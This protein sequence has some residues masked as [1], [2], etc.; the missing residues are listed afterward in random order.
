MTQV[1]S[2]QPQGSLEARGGMLRVWERCGVRA[3]AESLGVAVLL[4][5]K[6][7]ERPRARRAGTVGS[8]TAMGTG[9]LGSLQKVRGPADTLILAQQDH[10]RL[11]GP[12]TVTG[13]VCVVST[14]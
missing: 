8:G 7:E 11:V 10:V 1:G 3:V 2:M 14:F 4:A 6:A 13:H 5:T 9:L 12:T